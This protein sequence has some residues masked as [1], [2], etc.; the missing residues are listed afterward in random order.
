MHAGQEH[1][2]P[3][4][5]LQEGYISVEEY[6][7]LRKASASPGEAGD[8]LRLRLAP[9]QLLRL[10]ALV[11]QL[12]LL[13][14]DPP[15]PDSGLGRTLRGDDD[16]RGPGAPASPLGPAAGDPSDPQR[17]PTV[18]AVLDPG[19]SGPLSA[20]SLTMD[21]TDPDDAGR[22]EFL[23]EKGKGGMGRVWVA[24]DRHMG[25]EVAV[26]ELLSSPRG[27]EDTRDPTE[28]R[29]LREAL[30]TGQL[31]HPGVVPVYELGQREDGSLF[32]TMRLL[33]GRT[34]RQAI[35]GCAG[36]AERL[37]LMPHFRD[38]CLTVAYVHSRGVIHRDIKP[39]NI[40]IGEFGETILLDW[41]IAK[42]HGLSDEPSSRLLRDQEKLQAVANGETVEGDILGTPAYM[43]PEQ[44]CGRIDE[45]DEQ[46]DL[47]SLGAVLYEI[48]SG[49][50]PYTGNVWKVLSLV[51]KGQPRPL[52]QVDPKIPRDLAAVARKALCPEKE[53]RYPDARSLAR[54]VEDFMS[55]RK[56]GVYDYS[57]VELV[58]L[59]I[60]H[61][62]AL[63][64]ALAISAVLLSLAGAAVW[65]EYRRA[66]AASAVALANEQQARQNERRAWDS[67][68]VARSKSAES[69][70]NLAMTFLEKSENLR[71]TRLWD[72]AAAHAGAVLDLH[73][74]IPGSRTFDP[75]ADH[76]PRTSNVVRVRALSTLAAAQDHS[77]LRFAG[78][79][80]FP[81]PLVA[82]HRAGNGRLVFVAEAGTLWTLD[83]TG[84]EPAPLRLDHDTGIT[85]TR[86]FPGSADLLLVFSGAPPEIWDL[87]HGRKKSA[88]GPPADTLTA[89]NVAG[90][91]E[92]VGVEA[93]RTVRFID[94]RDWSVTGSLAI[95]D[96]T[97]VTWL[98]PMP[99]AGMLAAATQ[100]NRVL[101]W[102]LPGGRL[103][104]DWRGHQSTIK[105]V[106]WIPERRLILSASNDR[107]LRLW[108]PRTGPAGV[109]E[110]HGSSVITASVVPGGRWVVSGG[111]DRDLFVWDLETRRDV[112]RHRGHLEAVQELLVTDQG[113]TL[114]SCS[115]DRTCRKWA[116]LAPSEPRILEG[117]GSGSY[118]TIRLGDEAFAS[119]HGDGRIRIWDPDGGNLRLT[120]EGHPSEVFALAA[121]P[122]LKRL[123]SI[124]LRGLI[125][126]WDPRT[127]ERLRSMEGHT[128]WGMALAFSPDG[129]R[130]FSGGQDKL[131]HVWDTDT[132]AELR[133]HPV[134]DSV[135]SLLTTNGRLLV[136]LN[137]G[138][139]LIWDPEGARV[140]EELA[141][142]EK[143]ASGLSVSPDGKTLGSSGMDRRI[144]LWSARDGSWKRERTLE[145]HGA[146]VSKVRFSADGRHFAAASDDHSVTLWKLGDPVP[147]RAFHTRKEA[148]TVEFVGREPRLL[149]GDER[150]FLLHRLALPEA[151]WSAEQWIRH[152]EQVSGL[153]LEGI[154][155]APVESKEV[156]AAS[157]LRVLDQ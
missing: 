123:A 128:G 48:L 80:R 59:F 45:V 81:A 121:S 145:F 157:V 122:D 28:R 129:R 75:E 33:R 89:L 66:T 143:C 61:H 13:Q 49:R 27:T 72:A 126:L 42:V 108:D 30:V 142:H 92:L 95:P 77:R 57:A 154:S 65:R 137:S 134:P 15:R 83:G 138:R 32:Y 130:L 40:I 5:A 131:L 139:I 115:A 120:L 54:E 29:F 76:D 71:E 87:E 25:R 98:Y 10:N 47:Y 67:E 133:K 52:E 78:S 11:R 44:A 106:L 39:D 58:R 55:G 99:E 118:D 91:H 53:G 24:R 112:S 62:K 117:Q 36:L 26:K 23:A 2:I 132:G 119:A 84:N 140:V 111:F 135:F 34:L 82:V 110:G 156:P 50:P 90:P 155:L 97:T 149:V 22:Y 104:A 56:V 125:I 3:I 68:R 105:Q 21:A 17:L 101:L 4:L 37:N 1:L 7:E 127:G 16:D 109:L 73:P 103:L 148:L 136:G 113:R 20:I 12:A 85:L 151:G 100:D 150:R 146:W 31:E 35:S 6:L 124:D 14:Q 69:A 74:G 116:I 147:L 88:V 8:T 70:R 94:T 141:G 41:G 18:Q 63:A 107:T 9:D 60:R 86:F 51:Q 79:W 114:Y 93:G 43:P 144:I 96:Q 46:S 38:L 152:T 64:I 19:L 153:R 102:E